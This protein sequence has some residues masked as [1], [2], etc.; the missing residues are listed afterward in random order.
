ML[1]L[2]SYE[3]VR[4][5]SESSHNC[6]SNPS[7][8][9]KINI[10]SILFYSTKKYYRTTKILFIFS[11]R[12]SPL[13]SNIPLC[14]YVNAYFHVMHGTIYATLISRLTTRLSNMYLV[15]KSGSSLL[16]IVWWV[17]K[18]Y[19][20]L[21]DRIISRYYTQWLIVILDIQWII[22]KIKVS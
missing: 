1:D 7:V 2:Y 19:V 14:T 12:C 17:L 3:Q 4:N 13:H 21:I 16:Q 5:K 11:K 6:Q 18:W 9:Y 15:H 20:F 10:L 22:I 8:I